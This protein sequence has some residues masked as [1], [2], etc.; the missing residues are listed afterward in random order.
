M[1]VQFIC[2]KCG[3]IYKTAS[4]AMACEAIIVP[5]PLFEVGSDICI[6][7]GE[8]PLVGVITE[9]WIARRLSE[10]TK[11]YTEHEWQYLV[12]VN[13]RNFCSYPEHFLYVE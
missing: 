13:S 2:E 6:K 7:N 1:K 8:V 10:G 5:E 3:T 9:M 4:E 11:N 12:A